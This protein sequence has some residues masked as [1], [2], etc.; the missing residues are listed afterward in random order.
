MALMNGETKELNMMGNK[1]DAISIMNNKLFFE[2]KS[3][4]IHKNL[5]KIFKNLSLVIESEG[6]TPELY[7][8]SLKKTIEIKLINFFIL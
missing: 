2:D 3:K 7:L 8:S 1:I 5:E 4:D 6:S